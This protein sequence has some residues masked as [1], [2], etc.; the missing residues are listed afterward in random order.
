MNKLLEKAFAEASRRP[1]DEQE[2]IASLILDELA[3]EAAWQ[4]KF[5]RDAGKLAQLARNALDQHA[6]GQTTPL[7][8]PKEQ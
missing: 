5:Q 7:S 4:A 2:A 8:F 1:E 6:R 3:D